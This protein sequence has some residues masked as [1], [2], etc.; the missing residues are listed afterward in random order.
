MTTL[1]LALC[2]TAGSFGAKPLV[3]A[4]KTVSIP[5]WGKTLQKLRAC[6]RKNKR[7]L[8]AALGEPTSA[9]TNS[10][11][12]SYDF[13][14]NDLEITAIFKGSGDVVGIGIRFP[15]KWTVTAGTM[16]SILQDDKKSPSIVEP[17][18]DLVAQF[19]SNKEMF[20]RQYED[21]R[22]GTFIGFMVQFDHKFA[23]KVMLTFR[24]TVPEPPYKG[25]LKFN[26]ETNQ[27]EFTNTGAN[28]AYKWQGA[29]LFN[30]HVQMTHG[31]VWRELL[32][33]QD[34]N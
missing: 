26:A 22:P 28:P 34:G 29:T 27:R 24:A 16:W 17:R 31:N 8:V 21:G 11:G 2:V 19:Y 9:S 32:P 33:Y 20:R 18:V 6:M 25:T 12:G 30:Q 4:N 15:K 23:D 7:D 14:V 1:A 10:N 3:Q 5:Y 13:R